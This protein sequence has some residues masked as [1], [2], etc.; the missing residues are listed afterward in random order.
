MRFAN[1]AL[2]SI[3]IALTYVLTVEVTGG[4]WRLGLAAASLFAVLPSVHY[5]FSQALNDGLAFAAATTASGRRFGR[6]ARAFPAGWPARRHR[7]GAVGARAATML[8]AVAVVGTLTVARLFST[9]GSLGAREAKAIVTAPGALGRA[10]ILFGWFYLRNLVD[11]GDIGASTAYLCRSGDSLRSLVIGGPCGAV[12]PRPVRLLWFADGSRCWPRY[13]DLLTG[14]D[15]CVDPIVLT[16]TTLSVTH[17]A[18]RHMVASAARLRR[19]PRQP[20]LMRMAGRFA[21][22]PRR[23]IIGSPRIVWSM[24]GH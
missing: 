14:S 18:D 10:L 1:V 12:A 5:E 4:S 19:E 21:T 13:G 24:I 9:S 23:R 11:Y 8:V 22:V 20:H 16:P 17:R 7:G 15:D 2:A 6:S 3:G